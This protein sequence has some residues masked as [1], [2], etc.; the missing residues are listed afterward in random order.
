[1]LSV[2]KLGAGQEGYYLDAVAEGVEDY[3]SGRGESPG[4]WTGAAAVHLGLAGAVDD[5]AL[6]A[7]LGGRDPETG[8]PLGQLRKDRVP[9]FDLTFS[10]PKSVSVLWGLGDPVTARAVRAAHDRRR[11]PLRWAGSSARRVGRGAGST[12]TR[13]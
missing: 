1:M 13:S 10:A 8:T 12:A 6:R 11:R 3:Y 7:V 4:Q 2:S 9:G 5:E